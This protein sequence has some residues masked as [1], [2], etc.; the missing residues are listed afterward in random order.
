[1]LKYENNELV[2]VNSDYLVQF[3]FA[4]RSFPPPTKVSAASLCQTAGCFLRLPAQWCLYS[5]LEI[6]RF[7]KARELTKGEN[8]CSF[9]PLLSPPDL[10]PPTVIS[11]PVLFGRSCWTPRAQQLYTH[12]FLYKRIKPLAALNTQNIMLQHQTINCCCCLWVANIPISSVSPQRDWDS[13]RE[14]SVSHNRPRRC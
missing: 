4:N 6:R 8:S 1:M 3:E 10:P 7:F 5:S 13:S 14:N 2:L 9:Y 11:L 12:N